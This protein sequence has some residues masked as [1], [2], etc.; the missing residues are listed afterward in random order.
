MYASAQPTFSFETWTGSG[1]TIEPKG[2]ISQN[3]VTTF[4]GDP[5]SVLQ[6]SVTP[7]GGKYAMKIT[8]LTM[9]T[10]I[11]GLPNP[12]GLAGTGAV[13]GLTKLKFGFPYTARPA[14]ISFWYK[15]APAAN[16]SL[17]ILVSIWNGGP[18]THD[19]IAAVAWRDGATV[20][21]YTQKTLT[22]IYNP[23]FASEFPDSMAIMFSSTKLFNPNYSLCLNCG[24]AGSTLWVDDIN[25]SGINGINEYPS[26]NGVILYPN[27][28]N[29]FVNISVDANDAV[30]AI[31]YDA[32]GRVASISPAFEQMT[33]ANR[34]TGKINTSDLAVGLYS[35]S[36][37][38]KSGNA[39]KA[40]KFSVVR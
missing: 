36:V 23:T 18:T 17:D 25:L 28:A 34:K 35:Y 24:K 33:G 2:W 27:P 13:V 30:S 22:F 16:D 39:L 4:T 31:V 40:G 14:T 20:N 3:Y 1:T 11:T 9:G 38:D 19:T 15:Y 32:T 5:A 8:S 7:H 37:V 26:S 10:P 21:S 12:I 6:D 29:E